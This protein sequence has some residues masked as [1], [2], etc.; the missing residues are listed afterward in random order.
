MTD[1]QKHASKTISN[2]T[3]VPKTTDERLD[4]LDSSVQQAI[5]NTEVLWDELR[6]LQSKVEQQEERIKELEDSQLE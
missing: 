2:R 6:K 5:G 1:P 4:E 3:S